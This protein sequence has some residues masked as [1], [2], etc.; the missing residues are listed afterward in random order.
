[1]NIYV[2]RISNNKKQNKLRI[3]LVGD[4]GNEEMCIIIIKSAWIRSGRCDIC[5]FNHSHFYN[6]K[7]LTKL[8]LIDFFIYF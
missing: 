5:N 3:K 1:M 8:I 2:V 7:K 4:A 6:L